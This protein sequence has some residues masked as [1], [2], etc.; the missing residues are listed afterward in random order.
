[1]TVGEIIGIIFGCFIFLSIIS[2]ICG[3]RNR[4]RVPLQQ[5]EIT[6]PAA[7]NTYTRNVYSPSAQANVRTYA[8]PAASA[9]LPTMQEENPPSYQAY[10]ATV[11]PQQP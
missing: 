3:C 10:M 11:K 9:V 2:I 6:L 4:R 7:S 5:R 8:V 1:M